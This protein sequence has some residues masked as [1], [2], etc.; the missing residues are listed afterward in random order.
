MN[1]P[2]RDI[3]AAA[4][5]GESPDNAEAA[6]AVQDSPPMI[7][8]ASL[9]DYLHGTWIDATQDIEAMDDQIWQVLNRSNEPGAEEVA[10][11]DYT[12]FGDWQPDDYESLEEIKAAAD[13][14]IEHG[15]AVSHWISYLGEPPSRAVES[16]EDAYLG[17]WESMQQYAEVLAEDLGVIVTVDPPSWA[18]YAGIDYGAVARDLDIDLHSSRSAAG[19][20]HLFDPS[21][22][23]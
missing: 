16:F 8:M 3:A 21:R 22:L 5:G 1:N 6:E 4:G 23:Q 15:E 13:A 14:I 10:I 7:Y 2:E 11:H 17:S 18:H 12:G 19:R 20:L 9:A